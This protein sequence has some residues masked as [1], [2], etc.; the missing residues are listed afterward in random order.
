MERYAT[1]GGW[2]RCVL[3]HGKG[4]LTNLDTSPNFWDN[5]N[6]ARKWHN[7]QGLINDIESVLKGEGDSEGADTLARLRD[8]L[9]D[10]L[11][12]DIRGKMEAGAERMDELSERLDELESGMATLLDDDDDDALRDVDD[13]GDAVRS[14]AQD[15]DHTTDRGPLGP[16]TRGPGG[17]SNADDATTNTPHGWRPLRRQPAR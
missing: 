2:L 4:P 9:L 11:D 1:H 6:M 15:M 13:E 7:M 10:I 8:C 17:V 12:S 16:E 3:R 14:N 5:G